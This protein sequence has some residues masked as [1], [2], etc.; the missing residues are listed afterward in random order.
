MPAM[1]LPVMLRT[2]SMPDIA[3]LRP[4]STR[5]WQR[6]TAGLG[7]VIEPLGPVF[8]IEPGVH[9]SCEAVMLSPSGPC[10]AP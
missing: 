5:P 3:L 2:L 8:H 4:C 6:R 10:R 1:G 7:Y 9:G